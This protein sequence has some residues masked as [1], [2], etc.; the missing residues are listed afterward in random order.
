MTNILKSLV[1]MSLV[2]AACTSAPAPRWERPGASAANNAWDASDCSAISWTEAER[3]HPFGSRGGSPS[4]IADWMRRQQQV[5]DARYATAN[6][7]FDQCMQNRG[8]A[9]VQSGGR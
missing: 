5:D 2:L 3:L 9:K 6:R 7:L 1:L 4:A 8:Y